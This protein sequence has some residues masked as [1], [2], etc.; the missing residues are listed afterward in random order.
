MKSCTLVFGGD[1]FVSESYVLD[2]KLVKIFSDVDYSF[3]NL[4]GP[5]IDMKI[6]FN[7]K[8]EVIKAGPVIGQGKS[9]LEILQDLK[10][11]GLGCAN[12][13]V[14]DY[15]NLGVES[16]I[17]SLMSRGIFFAGVG[18]SVE[19]ALK[20]IVIEEK[21]VAI[22][23]V[24]EDE[25][26]IV[27]GGSG[28]FGCA[29]TYNDQ[30]LKE[31]ENFKRK[32]YL[33]IVYAHGGGEEIPLP[34]C[35]IRNRYRQFIDCGATAV[36]AHHPHVVQGIEKY[37]NG[38]IFY[39]LGNFVHSNSDTNWGLIVKMII[40]KGLVKY[41]IFPIEKHARLIVLSE[42]SHDGFFGEI[43]KLTQ[44]GDLY[45]EVYCQQAVYMYVNYYRNYFYEIFKLD[46]A[47]E[48]VRAVCRD[49]NL[50][51]DNQ[52]HQ[53]LLLSLLANKSHREFID[54]ALRVLCGKRKIERDTVSKAVL[55]KLM[56]HIQ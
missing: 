25:L 28:L 17:D 46:L 19:D 24:C 36:I 4:E 2:P 10:I 33:I 53:V 22:F 16:T 34:S 27:I 35:Y 1:L 29:S 6:E 5:I 18:L 56:K 42:N 43:D 13:H 40:S 21:K 54:S 45:E 55:K 8:S 26:N 9:C 41:E 39:S 50:F 47:R 23:C 12:N 37:K 44:D 51:G 38:T 49:R 48:V 11:Y 15:G 30:T 32:K 14:C 7:K 52:K 20:P 31:I 3:L